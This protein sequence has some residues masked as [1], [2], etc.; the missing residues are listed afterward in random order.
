MQCRTV[1]ISSGSSAEEIDVFLDADVQVVAF[2]VEM[3]YI[4]SDTPDVCVA[5]I[6]G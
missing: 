1:W 3:I 5:S 2:L 4:K 6:L